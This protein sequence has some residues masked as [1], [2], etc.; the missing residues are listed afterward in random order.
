MNITLNLELRW[1]PVNFRRFL[2]IPTYYN[3]YNSGSLTLFCLAL[4][5]C[6]RVS[7][8]RYILLHIAAARVIEYEDVLKCMRVHQN[9]REW[10]EYTSLPR[11]HSDTWEYTKIH[12][13]LEVTRE[14]SWVRADEEFPTAANMPTRSWPPLRRLP[15]RRA[16]T[17]CAEHFVN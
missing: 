7:S 3:I 5:H 11:L 9:A 16:R 1:I 13:M 15:N 10:T 8:I 17:S 6:A 4:L 12:K 14:R 2:G